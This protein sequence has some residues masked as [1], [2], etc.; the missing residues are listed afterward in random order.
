M[1]PHMQPPNID[2]FDWLLRHASEAKYNFAF[3]NIQGITLEEYQNLTNFSI[4]PDFDLGSNQQYGATELKETLQL[5]YTCGVDNIVT[6]TGASE[7]NFLVFSSLLSKGD[8]FIIEQPGY[9]PM[10]L[11][12][13]MLGALRIDWPR[14][15]EHKF[16]VQVEALNDLCT[17]KTKL[18]VLTN[19]HNPSGTYTDSTTIKA[20]A[21]I[22]DDNDAYVLVD[23]IFLDGSPTKHLS[24]Y[25]TPN[26]IVTSSATKIYGLGGLHTG[27][28]IAPEEIAKR[29][30]RMKAHT[31]GAS[32]FLSEFMTAHLLKNARDAVIERFQRQATTNRVIVKKWMERHK[33]LLQW[34]EPD[35][36]LVCFPKYSLNIPSVDLCRHLFETQ[37]ILINPGVYFNSEGFIRLSFGGKAD[38]L[39]QGLERLEHGLRDFYRLI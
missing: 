32:S 38:M 25:G 37:K 13:E 3:S 26:V 36:G 11:T 9:Q 22:A 17:K 21:E 19:L 35:G 29:C 30:Q 18:I 15:F 12:P 4:P 16:R 6:S 20:I 5:M 39:Q 8:E 23:E 2:L 1:L 33:D 27:W 14:S 34:V 24:C 31:T 7:A 10:W 28:I